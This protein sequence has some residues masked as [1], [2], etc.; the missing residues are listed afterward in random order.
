[1][2]DRGAFWCATTNAS[3][4]DALLPPLVPELP[5]VLDLREELPN[6]LDIALSPEMN[7]DAAGRDGLGCRYF[8][9]GDVAAKRGS[10]QT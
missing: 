8:L 1:M 2:V 10:I 7:G 4:F 3:R 6:S 5:T 9:R